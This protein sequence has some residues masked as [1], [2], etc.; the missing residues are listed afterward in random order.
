M[1]MTNVG[2][3][4]L[5]ISRIGFLGTNPSDFQQSN[6]CGTSLADPS[7]CQID[8]T[9]GPKDRGWRTTSLTVT[10][11]TLP[12]NQSITLFGVATSVILSPSSLNFGNQKVGTVSD[13]QTVTLTNIGNKPVSINEL[14]ILGQFPQVFLQT[15]N[16]GSSVAAGAS[17]TI[18]VQFAPQ[19][20]LG[21]IESLAVKDNGGGQ[22]Q[23]IQVTGTGT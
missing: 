15:N 5:D 18:N 11:N 10:A 17:C 20:T 1:I 23:K 3:Q 7:S 2:K 14:G 16:C 13:P 4:S 22:M 9:F 19:L 8:V 21:F 6:N 12:Q